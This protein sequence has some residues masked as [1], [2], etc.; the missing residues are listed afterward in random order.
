MEVCNNE[1]KLSEFHRL[2]PAVLYDKED[3]NLYIRLRLIS[4]C[5]TNGIFFENV[6]GRPADV[7]DKKFK[8]IVARA[9]DEEFFSRDDN[10]YDISTGNIDINQYIENIKGTA[11]NISTGALGV[12]YSTF[13]RNI[14]NARSIRD[15]V[16]VFSVPGTREFSYPSAIFRKDSYISVCVVDGEQETSSDSSSNIQCRP[17]TCGTHK[18]TPQKML[19]H[20]LD[21]QAA[22]SNSTL[23]TGKEAAFVN[24][25]Y[26]FGTWSEFETHCIN[27][28]KSMYRTTTLLAKK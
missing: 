17:K 14:I 10:F 27:E 3:F 1:S 16:G 12:Q 2:H 5:R 24:I 23:S 11:E 13:R 18:S 25:L 26:R 22:R 28:L 21:T 15:T 8:D 19:D 20:M 7:N 6:H 4:Y 9:F